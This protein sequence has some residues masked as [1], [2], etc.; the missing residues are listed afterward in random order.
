MGYYKPTEKV[1]KAAGKTLI[2]YGPAVFTCIA[3]IC[4][5]KHEDAKNHKIAKEV[6]E[7]VMQE[8]ANKGLK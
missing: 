5:I 8:L 6:A 4:S 2:T 3:S 1:I 7:M